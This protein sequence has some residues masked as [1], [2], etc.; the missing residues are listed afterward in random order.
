M[1]CPVLSQEFENSHFKMIIGKETLYALHT[2]CMRQK[3]AIHNEIYSFFDSKGDGVG[4]YGM[5][6]A[7]SLNFEENIQ[8]MRSDHLRRNWSKHSI[9]Y[10]DN[11]MIFVLQRSIGIAVEINPLN[12]VGTPTRISGR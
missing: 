10:L 5:N 8:L 4:A 9:D 11:L 6:Y 7:D 2:N 3:N 1:N 12:A